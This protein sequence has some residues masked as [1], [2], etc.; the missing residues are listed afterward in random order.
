M[1]QLYSRFIFLT[2]SLLISLW[3]RSQSIASSNDSS[4]YNR[5]ALIDQLLQEGYQEKLFP[6]ISA[7]LFQNDS[8]TYFNYGFAKIEEQVKTSHRIKYQ[9]GSIGKLLTA[10]AVLQQVERGQ[11]DLHTDINTYLSELDVNFTFDG[12]PVTL[13][14]LLTHS[15]GFNDMNIGYMAKSVD[16]VLPLDQ[17]IQQS[18]PGLFQ[19][20]ETDINY[21]NFSY[22]LA[23]LVVEKVSDTPFAIYVEENIFNPLGMHQASLQFPEGYQQLINQANTYTPKEESF[24]LQDIYP[25]HAV[26]AGSIVASP[27]DMGKFIQALYKRDN[28][29]LS[30]N[31]WDLFYQVHFSNHPLLN[32]Y[33]YGLEQQNI[34]GLASWAKGGMLPGVLSHILIVPGAF[35]YFSVVNTNDDQF[36]EYFIKSLFDSLHPNTVELKPR[37]QESSLEQYAGEYRDKRYNRNAPENII[38]LFKGAFSVYTNKSGDTLVVYHNGQFHD[39]IPIEENVFQNT[40][41][42]YEYLIFQKD[43]QGKLVGL[44]RNLNI[45]GLSIPVSYE[46][47]TWYNSPTFIN[48]HYAIILLIIFSGIF[49]MITSLVIRLIRLVRKDFWEHWLLHGWLLLLFSAIIILFLAHTYYGPFNLVINM[50]EFLLG[51]TATFQA[52]TMIG[53]WIVFLSACFGIS[54]VIMWRKKYS[55]LITRLYLTLVGIAIFIH[56]AFLYYWSFL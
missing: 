42:P 3:G 34:N 16:D 4:E 49:F 13:H 7:V 6:G 39:Y 29:L 51:Y 19:P 53:Y 32:G 2:L 24:E 43:E 25:R 5:I 46:T 14:C 12:Q 52:A 48:E 56:I 28:N 17:Y 30:I 44:Y 41:L 1:V 21:S 37:L 8:I 55:T 31:T 36:G 54:L 11:I 47:T 40:G 33:A 22:A 50:Q 27:E 20:P 26:P 9:L 15:C 23:G 38:S 45:G 10:I 35:A 18:N